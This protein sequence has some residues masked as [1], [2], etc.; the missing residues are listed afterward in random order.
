M[1]VPRPA[2]RSIEAARQR[3]LDWNSDRPGP[4]FSVELPRIADWIAEDLVDEVLLE[5]VSDIDQ[6]GEEIVQLLI[7]GEMAT[8]HSDFEGDE[9]EEEDSDFEPSEH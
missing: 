5:G 1:S 2:I 8:E 7:E 3:F 4:R 9:E 6:A